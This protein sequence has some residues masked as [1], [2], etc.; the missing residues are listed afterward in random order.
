MSH[1]GVEVFDFLLFSIYPVFGI[2]AVE[3]I[4]RLIK[5]PKWIKLWVQAAVSIGFGVYYW[6]VLPVP[7]NFPLTAM[8]M[9]VLAIALIYQGRRAKIS[10]EK[11]PY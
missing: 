9:F 6:F 1:T 2:L 8:V 4:S 10:P 11:S 5:A 3:L 7:Q